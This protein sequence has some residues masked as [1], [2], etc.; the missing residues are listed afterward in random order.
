MK[1]KEIKITKDKVTLTTD[2][3][4]RE[5]SETFKPE[6]DIQDFLMDLLTAQQG[7]LK[8]ADEALAEIYKNEQKNKKDKE[9]VN[10]QRGYTESIIS[11]LL[12]KIKDA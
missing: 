6:G 3:N 11:E 12:K 1:L 9:A 5:V 7:V 2:Y 10:L 8:K 4:Q